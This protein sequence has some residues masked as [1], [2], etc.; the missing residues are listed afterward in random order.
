MA[1]GVYIHIPYCLQICTYCDFSKYELGKILPPAQYVDLVRQEI[2]T[3]ASNLSKPSAG[4]DTVYFGGGTPS[5]LEP[6][7]ILSLLRELDNA[8]L[9][10]QPGAE[11][12]IEI[13]PGTVD[14]DKL[15][16]YLA[17]GI[18]RF[19][20]G[21]QSFN[22]RLLKI[23]GRKHS[24]EETVASL[25]LLHTRGVNYSFDLLFAMPTQTLSEVQDDVRRA[26]QFGPSHLSAYCLTVAEGHP[27]SKGRAPDEEQVEMFENIESELAAGGLDRYEISNF[28]RPGVQ[29]RHN[30]LYWTDQSYWGL[31]VS[32]HS[33]FRQT[34]WGM[35]LWNPPSIKEYIRQIERSPGADTWDFQKNLPPAQ[36]EVLHANQ[37]LTDYC[38]TFLR[39]W[40]GIDARALRLKFGDLIAAQVQSRIETLLKRGWLESTETGW[41]LSPEGRLV[42]NAIFEEL[43]FLPED[44]AATAPKG[45]RNLLAPC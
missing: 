30:L 5:L 20:V 43:T 26:L 31:G 32:S 35:R 3:R 21:A 13:N 11:V 17:M 18:N 37:A 8:G 42:A 25:E 15:D 39:R 6:E 28:A 9:H 33:Y 22:E 41:R 24:V 1:F 16:A 38:H 4:L 14:Q 29:S 45:S 36:V 34:P 10:R 12:T 27:L 44:L 7:L 40:A 2:R 23:G 19:S